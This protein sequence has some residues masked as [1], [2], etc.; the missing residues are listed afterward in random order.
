MK[1]FSLNTLF[2]AIILLFTSKVSAFE[3]NLLMGLLKEEIRKSAINKEVNIGESRFIGFSPTEK[4]MPEKLK[5]R[6]IK[7]P[8][9]VEFTFYCGTRQY[10]AVANYE[11]LVTVYVSQRN[12][13]RGDV[14]SLEDL[15]EIKKPINRVPYQA[16][17]NKDELIGRVLKRS[18][19]QGVIL[20]QEHLYSGIPVK[21][22]TFVQIFIT[23]GRVTIMT[24][25]ILKS[26]AM[27]GE[28]AKAR[29]L[30]TGKEIVGEL[31]DKTKVRLLL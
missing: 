28:M 6:E 26:D 12:L 15:L 17:L 27:V 31:I 20:K 16:I 25:G 5:I 30:Q 1:G 23:S 8:S 2:I 13:K 14:I 10:R 29:C 22:G 21:R 18:I 4:C 9:S 3:I 7:R 19:S 24:D 11:I